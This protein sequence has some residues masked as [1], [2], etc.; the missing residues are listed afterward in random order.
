MAHI[1]RIVQGKVTVA[2][3]ERDAQTQLAYHAWRSIQRNNFNQ[4]SYP[5][6]MRQADATR[7]ECLRMQFRKKQ[8]IF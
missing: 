1:D 5:G 7:M 6:K 3:C 4:I 8:A 2:E